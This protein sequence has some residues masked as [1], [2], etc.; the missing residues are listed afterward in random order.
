MERTT[1]YLDPK[2]NAFGYRIIK[3]AEKRPGER[4]WRTRRLSTGE[5]TRAAAEDFFAGFLAEG[6][7]DALDRGSVGQTVGE[8]AEWYLEIWAVPRGIDETQA[9][10]LKAPLRHF[11]RLRPQE[12]TY[13]TIAAYLT[14]RTKRDKVSLSTV[15]RELGAVKA[16]LGQAVKKHILRPADVP[17]IELPPEGDGRRSDHDW[18]TE[19]EE[20]AILRAASVWAAEPGVRL[21]VRVSRQAG[22]AFLA[23]ALETGARR[24]AIAELTWDRVDLDAGLVDFNRPGRRRTRK[25]RARVPITGALRGALQAMR[26][27]DYYRAEIGR[28]VVG[29]R[30]A[31]AYDRFRRTHEGG[32]WVRASPHVLR[33]TCATLM[34]RAGVDI[35]TV[36]GVL[37]DK[38]ETVERTYG[39]HSPDHLRSAVGRRKPTSAPERTVVR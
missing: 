19:E 18:L 2:P 4:R 32:K 22:R 7:P 11:G 17:V 23:I 36:A 13:E 3:W 15:R 31:N 24:E 26:D 6:G 12:I 39:H 20:R 5:R 9:R 35:W 16:V 14:L 34:L 28:Y 21:P 27:A 25:R 1:P 10:C 33:H 29:E 30:G 8:L 38:A 37:A